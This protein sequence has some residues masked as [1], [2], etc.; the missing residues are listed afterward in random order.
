MKTALKVF[1]VQALPFP[2]LQ[3]LLANVLMA[4]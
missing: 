2:L 3:L 1:H 4:T